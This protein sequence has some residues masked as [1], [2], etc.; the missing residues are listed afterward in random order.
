MSDYVRH[1][2][3]AVRPYVYGNLDS[4]EFIITVFDAEVLEQLEN[5]GS[6]PGYHCEFRIGDASLVLE[7]S[8]AWMNPP[9]TSRMYVYVPDVDDTYVRAIAMGATSLQAPEDKPYQERAGGVQ[10][11]FGNTWFIATYDETL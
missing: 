4:I 3:G 2:F 1:G 8:D 9:P 10:D 5:L 6:S 11:S 7:A